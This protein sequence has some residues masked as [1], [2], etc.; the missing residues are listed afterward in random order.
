MTGFSYSV[1]KLKKTGQPFEGQ[2]LRSQ[3][4][5]EAYHDYVFKL[6]NVDGS[7]SSNW[8]AG[9]GDWGDD[10]RVV[11]TTGHMLEWA[12]CSLPKEQLDDPRVVKAV[13]RLTDAFLDGRKNRVQYPV[14]PRGHGLHALA[15]YNERR[16]GDAPGSRDL[17]LNKRP[18]MKPGDSARTAE[19]PAKTG[20]GTTR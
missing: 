1:N 3:K 12:V 8:F 7:F 14:G 18:A 9:R 17:V 16:F 19:G 15:I 10:K 20:S 11:E 5:V 4:F 2:W 6:Q 13:N